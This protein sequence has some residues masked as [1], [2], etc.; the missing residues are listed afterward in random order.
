[1]SAT[2]NPAEITF[3]LDLLFRRIKIG[4]IKIKVAIR[5]SNNT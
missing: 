5:L 1:M 3:G 4:G 2:I